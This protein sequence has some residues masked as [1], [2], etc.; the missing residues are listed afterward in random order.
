MVIWSTLIFIGGTVL[1]L[2]LHVSLYFGGLFVWGYTI[3]LAYTLS[4]ILAAA[5]SAC[6]PFGA[7]LFWIYDRWSVTGEFFNFMTN[8]CL[9]WLAVLGLMI[10]DAYFS[11]K[12]IS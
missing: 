10:L 3:Y 7:Q 12:K 6:F 5:I 2:L 4:G 11:S 1:L 8:I 9:A